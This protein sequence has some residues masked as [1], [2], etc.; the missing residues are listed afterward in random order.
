MK[1]LMFSATTLFI[2]L[3]AA[4]PVSA[5][6]DS[7][8]TSSIKIDE[9]GP[10]RLRDLGIAIAPQLGVSSFEYSEG[11]SEDA[12]AELS[13]GVTVEF[14]GDLRKMET[15]L[16]VLQ[17]ATTSYL[18]IPMNA[19]IRV[20]Q[21][22]PQSWYGKVGFMPA[23]ELRNDK[24]TNNIDVIGNLGVGGRF[25]FS[26]KSDFIVEA[27]FNRGIMDAIRTANGD[28]LNQGFLVMAGMT[29]DL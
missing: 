13:G 22:G 15:G 21:M 27:T 26:A 10:A 5:Q 29:F 14:G 11:V 2:F 24:D 3:T 12:K 17:T 8:A 4:F 20:A 1:R 7:G 16:L 25:A 9:E 28:N 23:F 6:T 18:T 19:K